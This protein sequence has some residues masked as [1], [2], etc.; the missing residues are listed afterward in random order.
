MLG[1]GSG[2]MNQLAGPRVI[3]LTRLTGLVLS[4]AQSA[5]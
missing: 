1:Q 5:A 2:G 3:H 4:R